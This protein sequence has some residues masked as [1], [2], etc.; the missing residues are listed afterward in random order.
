MEERWGIPN[1]G[2]VKLHPAPAA[3]KLKKLKPFFFFL[4]SSYFLCF[5]SGFAAVF[6]SS[7]LA[8]SLVFASFWDLW[9]ESCRSSDD[10]NVEPVKH[11]PRPS[12][13]L[14]AAKKE[15]EKC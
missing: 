3:P 10:G 5:L 8:S 2:G 4:S 15:A 7:H 12:F 6:L 11:Q 9:R 14:T 13:T 1:S